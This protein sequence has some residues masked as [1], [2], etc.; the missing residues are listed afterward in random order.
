MSYNFILEIGVEEL[1]AIPLI[2]ELHNIPMKWKKVLEQNKLLCEFDFFYTPRRL[3]FAHTSMDR[4]QKDYFQEYFGAPKTIAYK[5]GVLS[6]AGKSFIKKHN[7]NESD[8]QISKKGDKEVLYHKQEIVGKD[9]NSLIV[10]MIN[11]FMKS[12][13]FGKKMRWGRGEFEFIRPIRW[14][15]AKFE[16]DNLN[17]ECFGVNISNYTYGHR[18]VSYDKIKIDNID[19]YFT[20]LKNNKIILSQDDRKNIIINDIKK[21]DIEYNIKVELDLELLK[22]VI[23]ITEYP[24][25]LLGSFSE[26]FL[27]LPS[28]VITTSMKEHQRYFAV[29]NKNDELSNKFIVVSNATCDDYSLVIRGNEK[30]LSARLEDALFFYTNDSRNKLKNDGLEK[31][32]FV[33]KLGNFQDKVDREIIISKVLADVFNVDN[34][35]ISRAI[36]LSKADLMSE[37]VYEFTELQGIMGSYYAKDMGESEEVALAI[38]EQYL[39]NSEEGELPSNLYSAIT[40]LAYKIDL[41]FAL[42]S[43]N[44]IPSGSKDPYALRRACIGII[45]IV[46]SFSLS[47]DLRYVF[48][49]TKSLYDESLCF[50]E[51]KKFFDERFYNF[52]QANRSVISSILITNETNLLNIINKIK[53]LDEISRQDNF[54]DNFSFIKRISNILNK[55]DNFEEIKIEL[56][57]NEF[58]K[59]LYNKF[60]EIKNRN[61][62]DYKEKLIALFSLSSLL[63]EF[64][65]NVMVNVDDEKVKINRTSLIYEINKE[66]KSIADIKMISSKMVNDKIITKK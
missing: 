43:I 32:V 13:N 33:N 59:N 49:K 5:D 41:I 47:F 61:I 56:F 6:N 55:A 11:E 60:Q 17:G 15:L 26:K 48:E 34:K 52:S 63:S 10:E 31:L 46:S 53:A 40:A 18:S 45:R 28:I 4:K 20:A 62:Q 27:D 58:E 38:K 64:F 30:V 21:I 44:L 42:F 7:I 65:D 39:P 24:K 54:K 35:I 19:E 2:K 12:L 1:P 16:N 8:I 3:V 51:V 66:F 36:F 9:I 50:D 25:V 14:I 23:A 37:M 29:F 57:D 22:E